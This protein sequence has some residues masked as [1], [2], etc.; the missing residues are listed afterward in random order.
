MPL[1][2]LIWWAVTFSRTQHHPGARFWIV[3]ALL[4]L[5]SLCGMA[6]SAVKALVVNGP[7]LKEILITLDEWEDSD[8]LDCLD[9]RDYQDDSDK[10]DC[11]D[12]QDYSDKQDC[13]DP[14]DSN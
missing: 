14:Q 3:C 12:K 9:Y 13:S 8:S 11:S 5:L 2:V 6:A 7:E 1:Y 10:Q 4:W